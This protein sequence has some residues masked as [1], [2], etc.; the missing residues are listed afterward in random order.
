M[1]FARDRYLCAY[2]GERFRSQFLEMEHVY[3]RS[4]GGADAWMNLVTACRSCNDRKRARTPEEARMPLLYLPYVPNRH[5]AFILG[6]RRILADQMEFLVRGIPRHSRVHAA[7]ATDGN[8]V[9]TA[10]R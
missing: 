7:D 6:N 2:C 5:E 3:P 10:R 9:G 4:R 1:L 8:V